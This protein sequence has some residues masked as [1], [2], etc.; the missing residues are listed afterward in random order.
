MLSTELQKIA[1]RKKT[2]L[3]AF[4]SLKRKYKYGYSNKIVCYRI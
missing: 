4:R 1:N 2:K 3:L